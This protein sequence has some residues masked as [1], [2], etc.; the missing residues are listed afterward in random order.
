MSSVFL[1]QTISPI[2]HR[3]TEESTYAGRGKT[4]RTTDCGDRAVWHLSTGG[5][6]LG[7]TAFVTIADTRDFLEKVIGCVLCTVVQMLM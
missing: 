6:L 5:E 4:L 2:R 1:L 7:D 3:L